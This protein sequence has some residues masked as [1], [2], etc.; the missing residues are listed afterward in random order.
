MLNYSK[1]QGKSITMNQDKDNKEVYNLI[2]R[3]E[4][5]S[6]LTE[7]IQGDALYI[8]ITPNGCMYEVAQGGIT[9]ASEPT[10]WETGKN[11]ITDSGSAKF[12][13]LPYT[14]ILKTGDIIQAN[15]S[16]GWPSY[17]LILPT[18]VTIDSD[19]LINS[20]IVQFRVLTTPGVGVY[21]IVNRISVRKVSGVYTRYDDTIVLNVIEN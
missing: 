14:L 17:E 18:G 3:P 13:A 7:V 9:G 20:S 2:Y 11:S 21:N 1:V 6:A 5:W 12:K 10:K 16:L 19:V 4:Q 8:P 15:A